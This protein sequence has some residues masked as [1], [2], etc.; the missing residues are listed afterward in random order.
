MT[1]GAS[2]IGLASVEA[3]LAAW[4]RAVVTALEES[5]SLLEA[6]EVATVILFMLTRPWGMKIRDGVMLPTNFDL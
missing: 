5:G 6:A 3:M 1:G 4:A 2:G